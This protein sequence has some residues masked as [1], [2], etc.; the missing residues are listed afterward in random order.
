MKLAVP[1]RIGEVEYNQAEIIK[2]SSGVI[3]S[4]TKNVED[5]SVYSA[6]HS[7]ASGV[8][9]S[10]I[11]DDGEITDDKKIK[12]IMWSASYK[13]VESL[14]IQGL[15]KHNRE[16]D[17]IEGIYICPMCGTKN[18]CK[19]DPRSGID[20]S[21]HLSDLE[22]HVDHESIEIIQDFS[23]PVIIKDLSDGETIHE[24]TSIA[25]RYPTIRDC[26]TSQKKFGD[27]NTARLQDGIL[28][29]ALLKVNGE[30]VDSKFKNRYGMTLFSSVPDANDIQDLIEKISLPGYDGHVIKVCRG[31]GEDFETSVNVS[32][33]FVSAL[34]RRRRR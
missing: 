31:C 3:A 12:E 18:T 19:N 17:S 4:T 16:D 32:N 7:F 11:S 26:E 28:T 5:G 6:F 9:S 8:V 25:I 24:I 20:T 34:Q 29:S 33:F 10:L 2:P 27:K 1:I 21:D 30:P 13:T 15:I 22:Y 23:D 14:C